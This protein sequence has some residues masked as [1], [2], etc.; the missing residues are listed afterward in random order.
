MARRLDLDA[1]GRMGEKAPD[2]M[3]HDF[4]V[5]PEIQLASPER[6]KQGA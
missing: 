5:G 3:F 2:R 6:L 1:F 4:G